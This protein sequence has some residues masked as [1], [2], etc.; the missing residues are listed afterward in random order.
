MKTPG[1]RP[2]LELVDV[3][4]TFGSVTAVD[5]L[6]FSAP[7]ATVTALLG[8][9]GAG[10]TTTIEMCEGFATPDR[11][12]ISVLGLDPSKD[13]QAVRRRIGIMLQGG[14]AYPGIRVKEMLQLV[15]SYSAH[16]LDV[17]WLLETVG[18]SKHARTNYRRLSGGQ[19][20]R[21]SL[22]CALVGRPELVFLDEPTAGM[23][24]Q[25]RLAV[26]E[27][28]SSL[29][30]DGVTTILTTHLM[31]EAEA[32]AD[33]VVII[34]H[35][36]LVAQGT[37]DELTASTAA[38]QLSLATTSAL[39]LERANTTLRA[40]G[41]DSQLTPTRPLSYRVDSPPT[42]KLI[43][44]IATAAAE[45]NVLIKDFSAAHRSLE[46]VFLNITGTKM[47]N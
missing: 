9:N 45:Q 4:K 10:K 3:T 18:L 32:L 35:G 43:K 38:G 40:S 13:P 22:A 29:R 28:I 34:D 39:D 44:A 36:Q 21:L 16:P 33:N 5:G 30:Q 24:A 41:V 31:D 19:Q 12:T 14:G 2:A 1:T 11:G 7:P 26:W 23:D 37:P 46:D 47:R 6:S 20:Q 8:P 17:D 15:A 25:S 27:M 42:P